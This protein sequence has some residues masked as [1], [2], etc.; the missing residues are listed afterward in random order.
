MFG[1]QLKNLLNW[2]WKWWMERYASLSIACVS[3]YIFWGNKAP[4]SQ[5]Q[6]G[7]LFSFYM[8]GSYLLTWQS[9]DLQN[10]TWRLHPTS[11]NVSTLFPSCL[12]V[13]KNS[14]Q[15][16]FLNCLF[17]NKIHK[18]IHFAIRWWCNFTYN[19]FI[20][21]AIAWIFYLLWNEWNYHIEKSMRPLLQAIGYRVD[22][23]FVDRECAAVFWKKSRPPDI[24]SSAN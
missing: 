14:F 9:L 18:C 21:S 16:D 2:L 12:C 7:L 19:H 5:L 24:L 11:S 3:Q 1:L 17:T 20:T 8:A 6:L 10:C 15:L 13:Q 22:D 23:K 4:L